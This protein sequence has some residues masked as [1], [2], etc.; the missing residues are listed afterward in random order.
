[1]TLFQT[2]DNQE[3]K[4]L[5]TRALPKSSRG[6]FSSHDHS[7]SEFSADLSDREETKLNLLSGC[8]LRDSGCLLPPRPSVQPG[9]RG[10]YA[11]TQ[12]NERDKNRKPRMCAEAAWTFLET[13][14]R[15][16]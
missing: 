9:F 13:P 12:A 8:D 16:H 11:R 14:H 5:P 15:W 4:S 10:R 1:M 2:G 7:P 3:T 6:K